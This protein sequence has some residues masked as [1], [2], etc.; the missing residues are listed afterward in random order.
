M[1]MYKSYTANYDRLYLVLLFNLL[2]HLLRSILASII[3]DS[4]ITP[5]SG[6][7]LAYKRAQAPASPSISL[8][9]RS[10]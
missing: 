6:E 2:R 8:E 1:N 7:F 5:F 10:S 9:P 3:V 4:N